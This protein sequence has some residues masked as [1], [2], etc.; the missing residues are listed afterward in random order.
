MRAQK[1]CFLLQETQCRSHG[2]ELPRENEKA[3]KRQKALGS[4]TNPSEHNVGAGEES[5]VDADAALQVM[6]NAAVDEDSARA[7][8]KGVVDTAQQKKEKAAGQQQ[9]EES[10]TGLQIEVNRA[11]VTN[12]AQV[13]LL[14][15]SGTLEGF[16][17]T[18]LIDSGASD[19][20]ISSEFV[21]AH[22]LK[23]VKTKEKMKIFLADGSVRVTGECVPQV[24]VSF[25]EHSEF[26]DLQV[27]KLPKYEVI[28]GKFWLD[29]WNPQ[30]D[31][32]NNVMKW[33]LG[34]RV[35]E[36]S[37]IPTTSESEQ[38]SSLFNLGS[39]VEEISAQR[40]RRLAQREPVFL[41]VV[42]SVTENERN[43]HGKE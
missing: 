23:T 27:L 35:V 15:I 34:S 3:G 4:S 11:D 8:E 1:A 28:L 20:F 18:F 31:W 41:A 29:R 42:R 22:G 24:C 16:P 25:G 19:C 12:T 36:V 38:M 5:A 13:I 17:V 39:Y 7:A 14:C 40:M 43:G 21:R 33:K 6:E 30:I 32:K 10:S 2:K 26:L 37:G 9:K